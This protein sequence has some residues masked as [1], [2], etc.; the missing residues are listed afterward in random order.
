MWRQILPPERLSNYQF[1][2]E[3]W[4]WKGGV[5]AILSTPDGWV[6][7]NQ[8]THKPGGCVLVQPEMEKQRSPLV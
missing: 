6:V 4:L 5:L 3:V 1:V 8:D 2:G 7:D